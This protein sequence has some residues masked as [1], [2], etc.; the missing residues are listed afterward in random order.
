MSSTSRIPTLGVGGG[1]HTLL[2]EGL[3]KRSGFWRNLDLLPY[4][5]ILRLRS[6]FQ[7]IYAV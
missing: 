5:Q 4:N 1:A 6:P 7:A 3:L 2:A